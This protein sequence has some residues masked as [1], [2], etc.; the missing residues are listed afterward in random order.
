[1]EKT[2]S[3]AVYRASRTALGR[4]DPVPALHWVRPHHG[5]VVKPQFQLSR[6]PAIERC[7]GASAPYSCWGS[8][9]RRPEYRREGGSIQATIFHELRRKINE[10]LTRLE[11]RIR[12]SQG[13]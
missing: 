2:R 5:R 11:G 10:A 13:V 8:S 7:T 12:A 9:Y 4:V 1:M 6:V 3:I